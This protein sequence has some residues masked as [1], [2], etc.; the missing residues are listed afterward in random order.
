M[1]ETFLLYSIFSLLI[2]I[3]GLYYILVTGSLIRLL[4]GVE[5]MIKA[6]TMFLIMSGFVTGSPSRAQAFVITLIVI[7]VVVM[8]VASGVVISF[9]RKSRSIKTSSINNLKG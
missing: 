5:I 2:F 3:I 8:V 4:I 6:A 1:S 9:Y 7:E